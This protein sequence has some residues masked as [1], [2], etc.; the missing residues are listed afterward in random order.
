MQRP[1]HFAC[2]KATIGSRGVGTSTLCPK[3]D[4]RAQG[5]VDALYAG[6]VRVYDFQNPDLSPPDKREKVAGASVPKA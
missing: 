4:E 2:R 6:Q 5:R 3:L 1:N